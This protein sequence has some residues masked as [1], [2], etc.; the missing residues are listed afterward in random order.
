MQIWTRRIYDPPGE[1][2][3]N[4]IL[5]DRVWPRGVSKDQAQLQAWH[6]EAAPSTRLRK[7]FAHDPARWDDF[8]QRYFIELDAKPDVVAPLIAATRQ[9]RL[10]LLFGARDTQHNN[11]VALREYLLL[12]ANRTA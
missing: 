6:R 2:D 9:G 8:R 4:R 10:T 7:W 5:V 12:M 3:G 11:A 1:Q